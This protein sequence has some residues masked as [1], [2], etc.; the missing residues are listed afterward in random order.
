MSQPLRF[1]QDLLHEH[2]KPKRKINV[3]KI[4]TDDCDTIGSHT[5]TMIK[6]VSS[7]KKTL[8]HLRFL[9][10]LL[11]H[12]GSFRII[13]NQNQ[14]NQNQAGFSSSAVAAA[15]AVVSNLNNSIRTRMSYRI[16]LVTMMFVV[17]VLVPA[18]RF[19]RRKLSQRRTADSLLRIDDDHDNA[20]DNDNDNDNGNN[21]N[22]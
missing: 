1:E 7:H 15:A 21:K 19:L 12:S 14:Q 22:K 13:D 2:S 5:R 3:T 20:D 10:C 18:S 9:K 4:V 8:D 16:P 11:I 6:Y 17:G